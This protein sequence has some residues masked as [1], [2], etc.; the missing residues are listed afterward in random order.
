MARIGCPVGFSE[1]IIAFLIEKGLKLTSKL[2]KYPKL[3]SGDPSGFR[4]S[5]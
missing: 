2:T 3:E 1:K 5:C 4:T